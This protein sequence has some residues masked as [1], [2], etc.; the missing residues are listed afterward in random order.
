[1]DLEEDSDASYK[2]SDTMRGLGGHLGTLGPNGI[3]KAF[4]KGHWSKEEVRNPFHNS[5][6]ISIGSSLI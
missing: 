2:E 1:M 3:S 4:C 6:F 5:N